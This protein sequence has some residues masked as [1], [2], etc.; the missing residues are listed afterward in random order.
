MIDGIITIVII[1][2][3]EREMYPFTIANS[4]YYIFLL[5]INI[6]IL[7]SYLKTIEYNQQ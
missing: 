3:L 6:S 7:F 4:K 2:I 1:V 5:S